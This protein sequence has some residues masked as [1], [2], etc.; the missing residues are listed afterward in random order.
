MTEFCY[1]KYILYFILVFSVHSSQIV[2]VEKC[3]VSGPG[4]ENPD[5]IV[6]PARYFTIIA[7]DKNGKR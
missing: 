7:K 4:I 6:L 3:I 5:N 1:L 2:D